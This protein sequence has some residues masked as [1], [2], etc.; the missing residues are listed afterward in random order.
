M[1]WTDWVTLANLALLL[2]AAIRYHQRQTPCVADSA[3]ERET[4]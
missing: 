3:E 4:Q 1:E 2:F